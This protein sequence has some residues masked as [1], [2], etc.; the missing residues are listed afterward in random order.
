[1]LTNNKK[2]PRV[3][4]DV[5]RKKDVKHRLCTVLLSV[6]TLIPCSLLSGCHPAVFAASAILINQLEKQEPNRK[7]HVTTERVQPRQYTPP[8]PPVITPPTDEQIIEEAQRYYCNLQ[9]QKS[10]DLLKQVIEKTGLSQSLRWEALVLLGAMEYQN[11]NTIEARD[12]FNKAHQES[13]VL[14]SS[15]L[16]PPAMIDFYKTNG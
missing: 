12:Y 15:E 3:L 13:R 5:S 1:M 10:T 14:P 8:K 11:G 7:Q 4:S 9:W 6:M 2:R 16:F